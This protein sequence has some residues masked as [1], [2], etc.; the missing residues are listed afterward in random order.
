MEEICCTCLKTYSENNSEDH[1]VNIYNEDYDNITYYTKLKYLV[2][3]SDL[4]LET[5]DQICLKCLKQLRISFK[6]KNIIES[7]QQFFK[8]SIHHTA[9]NIK[10]EILSNSSSEY[11][12]ENNDEIIHLHPLKDEEDTSDCDKKH[13]AAKFEIQEDEASYDEVTKHYIENDHSYGQKN[14]I[15][16][17]QVCIYCACYFQ[18]P[19]ELKK[20]IKKEHKNAGNLYC[21]KCDKTFQKLFAYNEHMNSHTKALYYPCLYC[22]KTFF[23]LTCQKRHIKT[24]LAKPGKKSKKTPFLCNICGKTFPY[25]NTY[26]RHLRMHQNVRKYE[27]GVCTKKFSQSQHL[28]VHMRVH[29]GE[30][31]YICDLCGSAFSLAATLRKHKSVHERLEKN[32]KE[33]DNVKEEIEIKYA[34]PVSDLEFDKSVGIE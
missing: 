10:S 7:S 23:R 19:N 32:H 18:D 5:D 6:F 4:I 27:C 1:L 15:D 3:P 34:V 14:E 21:E 26:Q 33:T 2:S 25:T 8:D 11:E 30:K 22:E 31:P 29:T 13:F 28:Q 17:K 16:D 9:V 12:Q 24:H 20:H